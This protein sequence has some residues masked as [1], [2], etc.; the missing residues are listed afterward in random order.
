MQLHMFTDED[1]EKAR[2]VLF[3]GYVPV[4]MVKEILGEKKLLNRGYDDL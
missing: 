3:A 4:D 1:Q 2:E